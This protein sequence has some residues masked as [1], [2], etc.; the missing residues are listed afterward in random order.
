MGYGWGIA[1]TSEEADAKAKKECAE[2][3]YGLPA[4]NSDSRCTGQNAGDLKVIY[5]AHD[6]LKLTLPGAATDY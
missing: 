5:D 4:P 1:P 2:R 3:S 6:E